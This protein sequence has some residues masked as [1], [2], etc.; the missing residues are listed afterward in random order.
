VH[1]YGMTA[2]WKNAPGLAWWGVK[3]A[4]GAVVEEC[5]VFSECFA[6]SQRG[7]RQDGITCSKLTGAT[8]CGWDVFTADK[9]P[10]QPTGKWVGEAEYQQD[11]FVCSPG[12]QCAHKREFA[13][14]CHRVY[15]PANGFAAVKFD[16]NLDGKMFY[17][18]PKGS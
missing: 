14:F 9:T 8:P 6:A 16:V 4:D 17:P 2:A 15:A 10:G 3:Y 1:R 13:T 7:S 18:C 11:R 12:V 5:Y